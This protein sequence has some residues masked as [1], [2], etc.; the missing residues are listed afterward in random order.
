[1][2]FQGLR[3]SGSLFLVPSLRFF[4]FYWFD[5][6]NSNLLDFALYIIFYIIILYHIYSI[7]AVCFLMRGRK[8]AGG[9][10]MSRGRGN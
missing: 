4:S 8:G 5:L 6:S 10:G 7:E 3:M 1:M 2:R 9:S